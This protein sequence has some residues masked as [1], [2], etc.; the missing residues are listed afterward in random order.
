MSQAHDLMIE[1]APGDREYEEV[2]RL[3]DDRQFMLT[4]NL[5]PSVH[6]DA[7]ARFLVLLIFDRAG[8][9]TSADV[10]NLGLRNALARETLTHAIELRLAELGPTARCPILIEPIDAAMLGSEFGPITVHS[11]EAPELQPKLGGGAIV[12]GWPFGTDE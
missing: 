5:R 1:V 7:E 10:R 4:A 6:G 12:P 8:V 3:A 11:D 9:A 2:G